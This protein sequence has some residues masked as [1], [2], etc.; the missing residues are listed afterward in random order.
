MKNLCTVH[1]PTE[2][3]LPHIDYNSCSQC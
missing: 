1:Y 3:G 2:L